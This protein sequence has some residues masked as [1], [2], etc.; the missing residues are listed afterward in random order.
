MP[1]KLLSPAPL[2]FEVKHM[3]EQIIR[4]KPVRFAVYHITTTD[5]RAFSTRDGVLQKKFGNNT[6][7][8][9]ITAIVY[10][11]IAHNTPWVCV[12]VYDNYNK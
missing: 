6:G 2:E 10:T 1:E 3:E 11:L 5:A 12:V 4:N 9:Y 7:D 8:I